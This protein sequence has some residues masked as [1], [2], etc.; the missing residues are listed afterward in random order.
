[1]LLESVIDLLIS[2]SG[3]SGKK[4]IVIDFLVIHFGEKRRFFF[5][6]NNFIFIFIKNPQYY[7]TINLFF[8][9]IMF[10][11]L[12]NIILY[13]PRLLFKSAFMKSSG[14]RF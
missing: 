13:W 2:F 9:L 12:F 4:S 8:K 6:N 7:K 1:M 10:L 5:Y 3:N 14:I 11:L